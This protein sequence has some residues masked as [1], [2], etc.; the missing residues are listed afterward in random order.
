MQA[1]QER[2]IVVDVILNTRFGPE[3]LRVLL[4][5]LLFA[6]GIVFGWLLSLWRWRRLRKQA[7]RGEAR[8][9]LTMEKIL[10]ERRPD[11]REIMRIRSCGRDP[12]DAVFPNHAA[13]DAFLERAD[14]TKPDQ[15]LVSMADKLG[16][17]LL[18]ELAIWV[19]G[20]LRER[21]F[22]HDV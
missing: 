12:I 15:P 9:V 6:L 19:C 10:L 22:R 5:G 16:S 17:Y 2:K 3:L 18:Q 20:Q 21:G 1:D 11:G 14:H 7:E 8:E 13:R 4:T